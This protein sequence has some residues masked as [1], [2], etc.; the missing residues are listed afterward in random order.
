MYM[1]TSGTKMG[2]GRGTAYN[3]YTRDKRIDGREKIKHRDT[4]LNFFC[5]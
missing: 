5:I 2:E 4:I 3:D 1:P